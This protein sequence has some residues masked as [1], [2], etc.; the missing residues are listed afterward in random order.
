MATA[1]AFVSRIIPSF[2]LPFWESLQD[3]QV[4]LIQTLSN[5]FYPGLQSV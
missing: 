4:D 5:D 3:Q 1:I 2:L